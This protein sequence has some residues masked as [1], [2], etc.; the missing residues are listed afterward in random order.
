MPGEQHEVVVGGEAV[1]DFAE[2]PIDTAHPRG[3]HVAMGGSTV[4]ALIAYLLMSKELPIKDLQD[5]YDGWPAGV[6]TFLTPTIIT[7]PFLFASIASTKLPEDSMAPIVCLFS[8]NV[9]GGAV[10][11]NAA[12]QPGLSPK[13]FKVAEQNL[14]L[15]WG[16]AALKGLYL[17]KKQCFSA[18]E[19]RDNQ[20]I[21]D[22]VLGAMIIVALWEFCG[23]WDLNPISLEALADKFAPPAWLSNAVDPGVILIAAFGVITLGARISNET[24]NKL[25][26][27]FSGLMLL[28]SAFSIGFACV[29]DN[30]NPG[31]VNP[32]K[33][34][35]CLILQ[36]SLI[37]GGWGAWNNR[38][39]L[40]A[41]AARL[42][43]MVATVPSIP[44]IPSR[45]ATPFSRVGRRGVD[46]AALLP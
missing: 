32:H 4:L 24:A 19:P 45:L 16:I 5:V 10:W 8:F 1:A 20:N 23:V 11:F 39:E 33:Q 37:S 27:M 28:I 29:A 35:A 13:E 26:G 3:P 38:A 7:A 21:P 2:K 42:S 17:A 36:L 18:P 31:Q 6:Q 34:F 46:S 22:W 30:P 14:I 9:L 15:F 40:S 41:K 44:S 43:A 25:K 12:R